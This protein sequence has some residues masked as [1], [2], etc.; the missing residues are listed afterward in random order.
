MAN[1]LCRVHKLKPPPKLRILSGQSSD[2]KNHGLDILKKLTSIHKDK[3]LGLCPNVTISDI[4][5][6]L[7]HTDGSRVI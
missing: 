4:T 2:I 7:I 3:L 5:P 1:L 6:V